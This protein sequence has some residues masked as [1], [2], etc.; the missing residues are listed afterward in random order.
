MLLAA[1][2]AA[3]LAACGSGASVDRFSGQR[4]QV[5]RA[6][7]RVGDAVRSGDAAQVCSTLLARAVTRRLGAQCPARIA[8][9]LGAVNDAR[10]EVVAVRVRG[11]RA[12]AT[13][14]A[15]TGAAPGSGDVEL[16]REEG[17]WRVISV[18]PLPPPLPRP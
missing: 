14:V 6:V 11:P 15:G 2:L 5:A 7:E 9:A 8:P 16:V 18:G 3:A 17:R 13:V 12:T 1:L 4:R 10:L